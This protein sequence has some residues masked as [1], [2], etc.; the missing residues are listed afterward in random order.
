VNHTSYNTRPS[1]LCVGVS[2]IQNKVVCEAGFEPAA[3]GGVTGLERR[4]RLEAS[5]GFIGL[6][7]RRRRRHALLRRGVS[8]KLAQTCTKIP[9]DRMSSSSVAKSSD[10]LLVASY[11]C[12][13]KFGASNAVSVSG[14]L[15]S[16]GERAT[17]SLVLDV[18]GQHVAILELKT[19]L[20]DRS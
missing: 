19:G 14:N 8:E 7:V 13:E 3:S 10:H 11:G 1:R 12:N 2:S 16:E 9:A 4:S 6:F 20:H 18:S 17:S 15:P 5:C